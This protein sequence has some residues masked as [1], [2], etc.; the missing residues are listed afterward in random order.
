MVAAAAP[1][2]LE[3]RAAIAE[4]R[5]GGGMSEE[6]DNVIPIPGIKV[7]DHKPARVLVTEDSAG[8]AFVDI[9]ESDLRYDHDVGAWFKWTGTHWQR[10]GTKL[11]FSWARDLAR[12]MAATQ[13]SASARR[14]ISKVKFAAA[15]E[16]FAQSDQRIAVRQDNWDTD[17]ML[18][19]T[20]GG[21]VDL[22]TGELRPAR[23]EDMIT[24]ITAV[25]PAATA[26]CPQWLKFLDRVMGPD[27]RDYVRRAL[28]YALTGLTIE[29]AMFFNY[30]TGGNGKGTLMSTAI[31]IFGDYHRT[32]PIETFTVSGTDRHPTEL[33]GLRGARLVTATE[34]E[35]GRRWAQSRITMITGG[36][37]VSAR[38]MRQDFF[39]FIP[40]LK[41][42]ITGNHKPGL[43]S[44]NEAIRRRMNMLLFGV[45][46][47]NE[48]K[49]EYLPKKLEAEWPSILRWIIDGCLAWQK[50]GL[51]PPA[52]VTEATAAYLE[53]EDV[54]AA[55]K[56]D[57]CEERGQWDS[58]ERLYGS[59]QGWA[60]KNEEYD[61]GKRW[62]GKRLEDGGYERSKGTGGVRGHRGLRVK[63]LPKE[64]PDQ[65]D[66][67]F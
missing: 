1:R 35:E 55:W 46:I 64:A 58:I 17:P 40:I 65:G 59:Y 20:P 36:D 67:P 14:D 10:D 27:L 56:E 3:R 38:F 15:V 63:D 9:H 28:G 12:T 49:D 54:I 18:L 51:A 5:E 44:V 21:T 52:V 23:P 50:Q 60:T 43:R 29:H 2:R 30:G 62:F 16:R 48:E 34:T 25:A 22:R 45:K 31:A 66:I 53:S 39:D 37:T 41:L 24:K 32:V 4:I 19:G 47:S 26:E 61:G 57:E 6:R 7:E 33:A 8:L 11:A 13:I 42:W